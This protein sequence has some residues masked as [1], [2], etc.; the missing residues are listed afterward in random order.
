[1][2]DN[3]DITI[4]LKPTISAEDA[5]ALRSQLDAIL[6]G[7]SADFLKKARATGES[8][9]KGLNLGTTG[10]DITAGLDSTLKNMT[11]VLGELNRSVNNMRTAIPQA[12]WWK[13]TPTAPRIPRRAGC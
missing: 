8:V 7:A 1:M 13:S 5:K 3:P 9:A 4:L 10:K 11:S 6:E 2:A 12:C